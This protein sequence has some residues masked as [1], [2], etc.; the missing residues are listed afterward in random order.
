MSGIGY[1]AAW[2]PPVIRPTLGAVSLQVYRFFT[3][4]IRECLC[5]ATHLLGSGPSYKL[6]L[7]RASLRRI[8]AAT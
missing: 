3:C 6:P 1:L 4:P 2:R 8:A 5:Y 7:L